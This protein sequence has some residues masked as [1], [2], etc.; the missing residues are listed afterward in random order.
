MYWTFYPIWFHTCI[1]LC[2]GSTT[3]QFKMM[4]CLQ[5]GAQGHLLGTMTIK[6]KMCIMNKSFLI[7]SSYLGMNIFVAFFLLLLLLADSTP[8][9][10]S[11][12]P[13]IGRISHNAVLIARRE[14]FLERG[15][16][17]R[18]PFF[19]FSF[20]L[21]TI[22]TACYISALQIS[23]TF[24]RQNNS[25]L[26]FK[27]TN[28][29]GV[30]YS[31]VFPISVRKMVKYELLTMKT[32]VCIFLWERF[33]TSALKF[34]IGFCNTKVPSYQAHQTKLL[35]FTLSTGDTGMVVNLSS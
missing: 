2:L 25:I 21:C 26:V 3:E 23:T 14:R 20:S 4:V 5:P 35:T 11:T 9:A 8:P 31:K 18:K 17:L 24:C 34:H 12:V 16:R 7:V 6:K 13:L 1:A 22:F 19:Y 28:K 33:V 30:N 15:F 29:Y 27:C 10:A 32:R